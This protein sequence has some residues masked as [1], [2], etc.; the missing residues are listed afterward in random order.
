MFTKLEKDEPS[1]SMNKTMY[2][3]IIGSHVYLTSSRLD[4]MFSFGNISSW[5]KA[6]PKES[7]LKATK[8][9][10]RFLIGTIDLA[11]FYSYAQTFD[12]VW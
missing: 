10:L 11:L 5:F 6:Q 3:G 12:I 7:H 9:I 2:W 1:P 4:I 8:W